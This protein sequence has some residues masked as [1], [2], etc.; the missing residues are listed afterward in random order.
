MPFIFQAQWGWNS[1]LLLI[2]FGAGLLQVLLT[3]PGGLADQLPKDLARLGRLV[4]ARV[5]E[6]AAPE[7]K[8]P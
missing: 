4:A 5:R 7:K 1:N 6:Q 8:A 2:I 3:A